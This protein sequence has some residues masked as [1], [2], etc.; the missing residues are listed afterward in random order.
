MVDTR[1]P[2]RN[3]LLRTLSPVDAALLEPHLEPVQLERRFV[4]ERPQV[5]IEHVTSPR[6]G[7][8]FPRAGLYFPESGIVST[9]ARQA[10]TAV[11]KQDFSGVTACRGPP[12]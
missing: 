10:A 5:P 2:T 8:Y 4:L 12:S 3:H 7:L 11:R 9:I 1:L 6:A